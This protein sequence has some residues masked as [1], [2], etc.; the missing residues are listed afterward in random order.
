MIVKSQKNIIDLVTRPGCKQLFSPVVSTDEEKDLELQT[1]IRSLNW[2]STKEL[3]CTID[4]ANQDVRTLLFEAINGKKFRL[5]PVLL[6]EF[7]IQ[8]S[9]ESCECIP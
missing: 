7:G 6:T 5:L 8:Y 9:L 2:I 1:K 3:N 4:E